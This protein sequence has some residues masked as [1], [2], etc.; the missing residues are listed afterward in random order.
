MLVSLMSRLRR[1]E[2][3]ARRSLYLYKNRWRR[4]AWLGTMRRTAPLSDHW[5]Y[6]RGTPVDRYYIEKFLEA[7]R[8]DIH[9]RVLEVMDSRYTDRYGHNIDHS[10]VLDIDPTNP[11]ATIIADLTAA[12]SIPDNQFDCFILTQTLQLIYDTP[13]AIHH[14]HRILKPGGVLLATV[15][16]VSKMDGPTD[17]WRFTPASCTTLFGRVFGPEQINVQAYGNVLTATAFLMG[18]AW[19]ELRP[20]ELAVNDPRFPLIITIRAV[21]RTSPTTSND[22]G[23]NA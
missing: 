7:H 2:S 10:D 11:R 22:E 8:R 18:M 12:D 21:K 17:C 6:E 14:A 9:G 16:S 20:R 4:P 13:S 1:A 23:D 15:P 3:A 19:E 5:G